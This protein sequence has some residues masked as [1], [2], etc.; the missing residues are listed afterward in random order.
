MGLDT[1][2]LIMIAPVLLVG[3]EQ[4]R[5]DEPPSDKPHGCEAPVDFATSLGGNLENQRDPRGDR[6]SDTTADDGAARPAPSDRWVRQ[7]DAPIQ[8]VRAGRLAR[9]LEAR[10]GNGDRRGRHLRARL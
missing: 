8:R 3:R 9:P 6:R 2:A 1:E 5:W 10:R 7:S 4:D